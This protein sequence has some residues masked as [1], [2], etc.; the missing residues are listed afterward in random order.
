[1][2]FSENRSTCIALL[3]NNLVIIT[4]R[5]HRHPQNGPQEDEQHRSTHSST[6]S[7]PTGSVEKQPLPVPLSRMSSARCGVG[8]AVMDNKLYALGR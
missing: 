2:L 1:M 8:A 3:D 6:C 4:L 5:F 7:S